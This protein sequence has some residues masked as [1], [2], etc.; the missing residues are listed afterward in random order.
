MEQNKINIIQLGMKARTKNELYRILT[1][2][3]YLYLPPQK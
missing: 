1:D 2:D 3:A